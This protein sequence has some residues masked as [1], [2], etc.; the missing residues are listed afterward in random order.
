MH[1]SRKIARLLRTRTRTRTCR[2][3]W[4][5]NESWDWR[6]A[7]QEDGIDARRRSSKQPSPT[8][9]ASRTW[10]SLPC[11]YRFRTPAPFPQVSEARGGESGT[12]LRRTNDS[13]SGVEQRGEVGN[14]ISRDT[15]GLPAAS[16]S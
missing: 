3:T 16:G 4:G 15:P 7:A 10:A 11:I 1:T 12:A 14:S 5:G 6:K 2:P 8:P 13:P 9:R